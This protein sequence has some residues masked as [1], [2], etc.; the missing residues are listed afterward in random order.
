LKK[1]SWQK[2]RE[3]HK[4]KEQQRRIT[5]PP[6]HFQGELVWH[7]NGACNGIAMQM[8]FIIDDDDSML[9]L[10]GCKLTIATSYRTGRAPLLWICF[11]THFR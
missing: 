5:P 7:G 2:G 10:Q 3:K 6:L 9:E 1:Q 11:I 8:G 4:R